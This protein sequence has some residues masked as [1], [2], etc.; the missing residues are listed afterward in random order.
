M[1]Y[2]FTFQCEKSPSWDFLLIVTHT[3][4]CV[5]VLYCTLCV[6]V[7]VC[8]WKV[9][10]ESGCMFSVESKKEAC[11]FQSAAARQPGGQNHVSLEVF[12]LFHGQQLR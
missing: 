3:L 7:C 4:V 10:L 8:V 9:I 11:A 2:Q 6:C 12:K 5:H 1:S